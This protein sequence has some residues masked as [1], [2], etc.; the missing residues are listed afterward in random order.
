ML[1]CGTGRS[2]FFIDASHDIEKKEWQAFFGLFTYKKTGIEP[3]RSLC[4]KP[5]QEERRIDAQIDT[6]RHAHATF[7]A[8]GATLFRVGVGGKMVVDICMYAPGEA[9]T[10]VLSIADTGIHHIGTAHRIGAVVDAHCTIE[11]IAEHRDE[12]VAVPIG[13]M[14]TEAP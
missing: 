14:K 11:R 1:E 9:V 13:A 7:L 6:C 12:V 3:S 2:L 4:S 8:I 5:L 10:E